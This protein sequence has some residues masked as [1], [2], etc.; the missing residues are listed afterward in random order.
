MRAICE[1]DPPALSAIR[2]AHAAQLRDLDSIVSTALRQQPAWRYPSVEQL[3]E[4]I[5]RYRRGCPI[6]AKGNRPWYRAGE[7]V[8]GSGCP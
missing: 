5:R 8:E 2:T 1:Y 4:D 6:L 3:A 7:F